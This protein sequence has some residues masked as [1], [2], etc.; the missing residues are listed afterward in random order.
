[1]KKVQ[2]S[3]TGRLQTFAR[4]LKVPPDADTKGVKL[5]GSIFIL[6]T[7]ASAVAVPEVWG[8]PSRAGSARSGCLVTELTRELRERVLREF[9]AGLRARMAAPSWP[10]DSQP[11]Y[12]DFPA[13]ASML[14]EMRRAPVTQADFEKMMRDIVDADPTKAAV[15]RAYLERTVNLDLLPQIPARTCVGRS[16]PVTLRSGVAIPA[17]IYSVDPEQLRTLRLLEAQ[18]RDLP[19]GREAA[20]AQN[21]TIE[22]SQQSVEAAARPFLETVFGLSAVHRT[23]V[24]RRGLPAKT[25]AQMAELEAQLLERSQFVV[26]SRNPI[27]GKTFPG[28][29]DTLGFLRILRSENAEEPLEFELKHG[30]RVPRAEGEIVVEL[31]RFFFDPELGTEARRKLIADAVVAIERAWPGRQ[32]TLYAETDR[33]GARVYQG[34]YGMK[35][36]PELSAQTQAAHVMRGSLTEIKARLGM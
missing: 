33:A 20:Q 19:I 30:F 9:I 34:A 15:A 23:Y 10:A 26:M 3:G 6:L 12:L 25:T 17:Y 29:G 7:A 14:E 36:S 16:T 24:D 8:E 2:K 4:F 32:V 27:D 22:Q 35:E 13:L 5:W 28:S 31:G 18:V 1:M 11:I 21:I